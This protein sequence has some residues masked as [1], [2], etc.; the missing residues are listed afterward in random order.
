MP[1]CAA[2]DVLYLQKIDDIFVQSYSGLFTDH[3]AAVQAGE[4][5]LYRVTDAGYAPVE[6]QGGA[7]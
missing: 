3:L 7:A 6:M 1:S 4:T 5:L 2:M